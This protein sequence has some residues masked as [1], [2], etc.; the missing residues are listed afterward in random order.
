MGFWIFMLIV[1]LF[2]PLLMLCI[3]Q[4]FLKNPPKDINAF[5][6][7]RTTMSMKNLD[8]WKFAHGICGKLWFWIGLASLIPSAIPLLFYIG[9]DTSTVS[10]AGVVVM[11]VQM[12]LLLATIVPVE[13]A[14]R[15]RFDADGNRKT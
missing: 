7:Y 14:L 4:W 3:G 13:M 2:T 12:V 15:R 10:L 5:I 11:C 8:T 1:D 9:A 6:G